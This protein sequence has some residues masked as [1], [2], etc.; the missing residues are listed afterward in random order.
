[1]EEIVDLNIN[2]PLHSANSES[3]LIV[4]D[5]IVCKL[6][7]NRIVR[8]IYGYRGKGATGM[9]VRLLYQFIKNRA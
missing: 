4:L 6:V 5:R 1:M 2:L 8:A 9:G 7:A 3:K